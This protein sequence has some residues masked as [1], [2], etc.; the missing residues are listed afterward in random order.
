LGKLIPNLV[1]DFRDVLVFG[2]L[3]GLRPQEL[4]MLKKDNLLM[5]G[6]GGYLLSIEYHKTSE[7]SKSHKPRTVPLTGE[8]TKIV[9]RQIG[10]HPN[11]DYLFLDGKGKPYTK[12]GLAQRLKRACLRSGI[13]PRSPYG[14]RH[15][16]GTV[17]A[18]SGTNQSILAQLMGHSHLQTTDRYVANVDDAHEQAVQ[19][20]EDNL[21]KVIGGGDGS[22]SPNGEMVEF[23]KKRAR[24]KAT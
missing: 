8:A 18:A 5:N 15:T 14:L 20:M 24:R 11:D 10:E 21:M 9:L 4:R 2:L 6:N 3:T 22:P 7:S 13:E 17:Q 1:E 19:A 12:N 16:F 23:P